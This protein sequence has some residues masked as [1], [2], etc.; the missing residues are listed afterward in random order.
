M[1]TIHEYRY[2]N[3]FM[4]V[5][6]GFHLIEVRMVQINRS[7]QAGYEDFEQPPAQQSGCAI[8]QRESLSETLQCTGDF[9][10]FPYNTSIVS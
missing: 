1:Q 8:L 9:S 4:Q 6:A 3:I 2:Y 5:S 10:I 7:V